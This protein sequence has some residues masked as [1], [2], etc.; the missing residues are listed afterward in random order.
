MSEFTLRPRC[1]LRALLCSMASWTGLLAIA[2]LAAPQASAQAV[3]TNAGFRANSHFR[4][5][6]SSVDSAQPLGFPLNFFGSQH[7]SVFVNNNGNVTFGSTLTAFSPE[8]LSS[9][10][11]PMIAPFWADVDTNSSLSEVVRFG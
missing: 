7:S 1:S 3:R 9:V 2:T 5:D 6:D 4:T 11:V 8:G 10:T